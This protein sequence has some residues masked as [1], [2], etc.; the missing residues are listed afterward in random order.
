VRPIFRLESLRLGA[1]I[2]IG[3]A[4]ALLLDGVP[5]FVSLGILS[6]FM[7]VRRIYQGRVKD[8]S[9]TLENRQRRRP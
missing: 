4:V 1:A 6:A 9:E 2:A 5:L 3:M 7:L 8:R